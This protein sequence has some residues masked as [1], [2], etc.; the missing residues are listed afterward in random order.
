MYSS[1]FFAT[2]CSSR[3]SSVMFLS[4][5]LYGSLILPFALIT[6]GS[7]CFMSSLLDWNDSL[8]CLFVGSEESFILLSSR[9]ILTLKDIKPITHFNCIALVNCYQYFR[10]FQSNCFLL[11]NTAIFFRLSFISADTIL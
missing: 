4:Y 7:R 3:F 2:L 10:E 6:R 11:G 1:P 5:H 8:H 9:F